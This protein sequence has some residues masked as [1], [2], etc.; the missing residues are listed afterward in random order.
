MVTK[1]EAELIWDAAKKHLLGFEGV[2][3]EIVNK[4]LFEYKLK[5]L[6]SISGDKGL[7]Y[8]LVS[9]ISGHYMVPKVLGSID[10]LEKVFF[11]FNPLKVLKEYENGLELLDNLPEKLID[12]LPE[13]NKINFTNAGSKSIIRK[14]LKGS[15]SCARFACRFKDIK[16]YEDFLKGFLT[17]EYS[18]L[19]LPLLLSKEI[20]FMGFALACNFLKETG[21][22]EYL[23][24]DIHLKEIFYEL[25]I[26]PSKDQY[27]VFK[28]GIV[29]SELIDKDPAEVDKA[30]WL[31]GS[32]K[33]YLTS[34][35]EKEQYK[36]H[37]LYGNASKEKFV[38]ETKKKLGK[39]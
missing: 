23:K 37:E 28:S 16:N 1:K 9:A 3:S 29:F 27:D 36:R 6:K 38:E 15:Y 12:N 7:Y 35:I 10:K 4:H 24:P 18:R 33:F 8:E 31:I 32:R 21:N 19:A 26:S 17:N 2:D 20:Y 30:F 11:K 14:F 25:G 39:K 22:G 5:K 13:K 34:G